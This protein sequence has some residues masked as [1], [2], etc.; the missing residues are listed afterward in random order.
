MNKN[1]E[2]ID[3]EVHAASD[4]LQEILRTIHAA[5]FNKNYSENGRLT[6]TM[7]RFA[8]LLVRLSNDA[9][10]NQA[11][12]TFLTWVITA[13]TFVLAVFTAVMLFKM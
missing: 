2:Q 12:M 11:R 5:T 8:T 7:A 4:S 6:T 9:K 3:S 10:R 1:R 13:L